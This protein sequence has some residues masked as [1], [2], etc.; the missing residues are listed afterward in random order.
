MPPLDRLFPFLSWPAQWRACGVRDDVVAGITV[1][2]VLIPQA[3]AYA[4]LAGLPPHV[5]LYAALLP[6]VVAALFGSCGQLSTGPVALTSLLVAA[7]IAPLGGLAGSDVI[8]LALLLALLS[9]LIQLALGVLRLGWL[10]NLL[11]VPVLMG[12]VNAAALIICL[13]QIPPLLGLA[14]PHSQ[15]LVLDFAHA[16]GGVAELHPASVAF[17][18]G[19]LGALVAL[20]RLWPRLPGV[21]LVVAL[22]TALSAWTGFAANGGAVVGDVPSGLPEFSLPPLRLELI[23]ALLPAAFVVAMVSFMEAASS[24]KLISGRTRQPWRQD[25]ELIGQGLGKLAAAFTSGMPV[26]ASFSRS[27]LNYASNARTGLSSLVTAAFVLLAL[28]YLTPLLWHLPKPVLAAIILQA[29]IGLIDVKVL[30]RAWRASRDDGAGAA[31][32][33][34]ATLA[35]AP[36]IQNGIFTGLILSLALMVYRG[37]RPRVALLG[38][39]EDGTYRDRERFGLPHPHP[40]LVI[41]R[42]DSPLSFVTAATFEDAMLGAARAQEGVKVVLVSG[43]GINDID[44]TGLHTLASLV[45]RFHVQGQTIAFCGLKKQVIDAMERDGL[46]TRLGAHASYRTEHHALDALLPTLAASR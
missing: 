9:G 15:H 31:V 5:G 42:F 16:L 12:F 11:S 22:A 39:H 8:G 2:L 25:Q 35:F 13:T 7:S 21:P 19:S 17:G 46:W 44:A 14:M 23:A 28:L 30:V 32:T 29:V 18:L 26:S 34:L 1:A 38:L 10:L 20:K 36:N 40:E 33:F 37:M 41:L 43:A 3:L 24:A 4:K 45:E 6:A 27:A